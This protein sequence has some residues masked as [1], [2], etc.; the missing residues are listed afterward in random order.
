VRG[1]LKRSGL[2]VKEFVAGHV[3]SVGAECEMGKWARRRMRA[4]LLGSLIEG[5][6][7]LSD[8]YTPP[9]ILKDLQ[10]EIGMKVSYMQC[11]RARE[12]VRVLANGRPNDHYKLLRWMCGAIVRAN[13]DSRAFCE[14]EGSRFR[15]LFVAYGASLNGFILG[16]RKILFVDGSHLSGP[17][18]GT[19]LSAVALDA[20]D[21]LFDVAY[22]IVAAENNDEWLWFLTVIRECLGGLQ[23]VIMSDRNPALLFSVPRVFGIENHTYCVRNVRENFLRTLRR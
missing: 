9:E 14:L 18:E 17:Y 23:P 7:R 2:Y 12:Y 13:P 6:V 5:K 15:R 4:S 11:W 16:C 21:H 20:D 3:H 19:L 1:H 10:L 22:A 8:G